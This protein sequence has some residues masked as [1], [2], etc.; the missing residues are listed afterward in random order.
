MEHLPGPAELDQ[1]AEQMD[2][3]GRAEA[4]VDDSAPVRAR[5]PGPAEDATPGDDSRSTPSPGRNEEGFAVRGAGER[6]APGRDIAP[7]RRGCPGDPAFGGIET[8]SAPGSS[9]ADDASSASPVIP[10]RC[11]WRASP[12]V[13]HRVDGFGG[14]S[15]RM[16][17]RD[18]EFVDTSALARA[19]SFGTPLLSATYSSISPLI[20][21]MISTGLVS[22]S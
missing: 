18:Q 6:V 4:A 14:S 7:T 10:A 20:C 11:K 15:S 17:W 21:R 8:G 19:A 1:A 9:S 12:S 16:W 13:R 22:S 2:A 5:G 3:G